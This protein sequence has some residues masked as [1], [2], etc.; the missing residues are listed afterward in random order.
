MRTYRSKSK[1]KAAV[2]T[3][4][5]RRRT[6]TQMAKAEP[7]GSSIAELE[8]FAAVVKLRAMKPEAS[9][10]DVSTYQRALADLAELRGDTFE[11]TEATLARSSAFRRYRDRIIEALLPFPDALRAAREAVAQLEASS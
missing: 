4:A 8:S 3:P 7:I 10:S 6:V 2:E 11:L 1:A 9:A 5:P